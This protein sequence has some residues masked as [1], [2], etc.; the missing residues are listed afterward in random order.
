[1]ADA[2]NNAL[3]SDTEPA[4]DIWKPALTEAAW[5][6]GAAAVLLI[7]VYAL[8][9]KHIHPEFVRFMEQDAKPITASGKDFIPV[10][11]GK[12]RKAGSQYIIENLNGDEAILALLRG[13]RA[14][15]YPFIK[16]DL[17][18][19]TRYSKAKILWQQAGDP[20]THALKFNRSGDEVTQ[21]AMVYGGEAYKGPIDSIALLFYDGPALGFE[22]NNDEDIVIESIEFRPFSAWRVAE[23]IFEDWTNPPL[24]ASHSNN[25]VRG[26]HLNGLA[27]PGFAINLILL[28]A[29]ALLLWRHLIYNMPITKDKSYPLGATLISLWF[30][31]WLAGDLLRWTWRVEELTDSYL[32]YQATDTREAHLNNAIRCAR[33]PKDCADHLQPHF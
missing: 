26:I 21:I 22:N 10:S 20:A 28:T 27:P 17:S 13:F 19:F 7:I 12:G 6:F 1:M 31:G 25:Y 2:T 11:I 9:F 32:R 4:P 30:L 24:W 3:S 14:E 16:V 15:D 29:T 5:A 23:Q 18:G 33:F 8:A